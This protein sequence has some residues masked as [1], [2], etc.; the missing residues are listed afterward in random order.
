MIPI[1]ALPPSGGG[2][3]YSDPN[4]TANRFVQTPALV[5]RMLQ[6]FA[7]LRYVGTKLL[8]GRQT[9]IGGMI[10]Y[11]LVAS[12]FADGGPE[13]V[14]A[15]SSYTRS[16]VSLGAAALTKTQKS[17]RDYPITDEAL[18]S[19]KFNPL[20]VT[21]QKA[22][23]SAALA[24][25]QTVVAAIA[26]AVTTTVGATAHWDGGGSTPTILKDVLAAAATV[27]NQNLGYVPD[28]VLVDDSAWVSLAS[29]AQLQTAMAREDRGN[30]VYNG[31]FQSL[32]GLTVV[33][34]PTAN[35]P[36]GIGTK[37]WVLDSTQVGFIAVQ[38][39]GG[40]YSSAGE[41]IE[42]KVI[43]DEDIDGWRLRVRT[44]FVPVV[45]NPLAGCAV[46]SVA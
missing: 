35:M 46:T 44:N 27:T 37:A 31:D 38:D 22:V 34:I 39:L 20:V 24:I 45:N 4:I 2:F 18:D 36:G 16:T 29:N 1:V 14:A 11:E 26:S 21:A 30:T 13:A 9:A 12:I 33:H 41:L 8:K 10:M 25:D 23:N 42:Q 15:G 32:A 6:D 7:Q 3:S 17:G 43:R 40:G 19:Y 5:S 28:T